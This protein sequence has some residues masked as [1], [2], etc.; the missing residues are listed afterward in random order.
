MKGVEALPDVF[1]VVPDIASRC[2]PLFVESYHQLIPLFQ[3]VK[4]AITVVAMHA[5]VPQETK[6]RESS[7]STEDKKRA[8]LGL[9]ASDP[10]YY[11][12]GTVSSPVGGDGFSERFPLSRLYWYQGLRRV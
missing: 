7:V 4:L 8:L 12:G 1:Q 10:T 2:V 9:V 6:G 5:F 11:S 3:V